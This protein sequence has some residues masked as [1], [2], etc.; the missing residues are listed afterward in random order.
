MTMTPK[1]EAAVRELAAALGVP[2]RKAVPKD[3]AGRVLGEV[4]DSM[5]GSVNV[6]DADGRPTF[7]VHR[8]VGDDPIK[9]ITGDGKPPKGS[10]LEKFASFLAGTDLEQASTGTVNANPLAE[11]QASI[12]RLERCVEALVAQATNTDETTDTDNTDDEE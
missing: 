5:A 9:A 1:Q 2:Q 6:R 8:G 11:M 7:E 10:E 4:M 12:A 3:M